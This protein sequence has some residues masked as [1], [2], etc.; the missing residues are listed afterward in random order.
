MVAMVSQDGAA[1]ASDLADRFWSRVDVAPAS[2]ACWLWTGPRQSEGYGVV[3]WRGERRYAH[4]L[5]WTLV[6]GAIQ[7]GIQIMHRCGVRVCVRPE[8][9]FPA[10][11]AEAGRYK[12]E[13]GLMASG[14]R[15]PAR[16]YPERRARGERQGSAKLRDEQVAAIR[17]RYVAGEAPI[18]RLA[19]EYGVGTSQ[20]WRI[21]T[22][23]S[24]Q[25]PSE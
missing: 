11:A 3:Y 12:A 17:A 6:S 15:S 13:Q 19:R 16:L 24:R 8:H 20:I 14:D 21:V 2:D 7:P 18:T 25:P 9:L 1:V 10:T 23:Q 5:V 4:R 22:G